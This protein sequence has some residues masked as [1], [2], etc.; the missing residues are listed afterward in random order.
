MTTPPRTRR[1]LAQATRI[2]GVPVQRQTERRARVPG[3]PQPTPAD[4]LALVLADA[5]RGYH[6]SR[7]ATFAW[8]RRWRFDFAIIDLMLAVEVE[9]GVWVGGRHTDP[10]GF[11]SDLEKYNEA[12]LRGWLVLRVTPEMVENGQALA[13]VQRAIAWIEP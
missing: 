4:D 5:L 7:E 13:L 6:V 3:A 1:L 2:A 10:K 11:L 12:A 8:P 9:G